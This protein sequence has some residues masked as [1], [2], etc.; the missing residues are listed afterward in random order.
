MTRCNGTGTDE[1]KK[2]SKEKEE[3]GSGDQRVSIK[4]ADGKTRVKTD[5][6]NEAVI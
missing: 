2:D 6:Q 3:A 4:K 5:R 1:E